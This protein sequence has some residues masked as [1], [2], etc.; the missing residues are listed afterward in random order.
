M[1]MARGGGVPS[2][3]WPFFVILRF[4]ECRN[5]IQKQRRIRNQLLCVGNGADV[6]I[7]IIAAIENDGRH[8]DDLAQFRWKKFCF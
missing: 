8:G 4:Q 1:N 2:N 3:P 6:K 7:L 5:G